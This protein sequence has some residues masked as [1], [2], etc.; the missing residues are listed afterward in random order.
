VALLRLAYRAAYRAL[1][2][3]SFV[4]RPRVGGVKCLLRDE[5]GRVLF[6]RHTYGDRR[7][8]EI[9]GGG[10][11]A[12]EDPLAGARREAH[13]EVGV[14][15]ADWARVGHVDG[16]WYFKRERLILFE[17]AWPRGTRPR[18]DPVEIGDA[19]W[20]AADAPPARLGPATRAA[21]QLLTTADGA[22]GA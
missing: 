5:R 21:L 1:I 13:E 14:D 10:L 4:V 2:A 17:A 11:K 12:G 15:V 9:P 6:V 19:A 16:P 18:F 8:W 22:S 7:A 3:Y 20:F